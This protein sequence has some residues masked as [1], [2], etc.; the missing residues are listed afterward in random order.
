MRNVLSRV[1]L[2]R[3]IQI[4]LVL[5]A[6]AGIA[7][8]AW[9]RLRHSQDLSALTYRQLESRAA[10]GSRDPEV[11]RE[12]A[13]RCINVRQPREA[14]RWLQLVRAY[15]PYNPET[16]NLE[17]MAWAN[18]GDTER[19]K[20]AFREAIQ[21]DPEAEEP[22][23]N[24]GRMALAQGA[25]WLATTEFEAAKK[26]APKDPE[27]HYLLGLALKQRGYAVSAK[28]AIRKAL[29]LDPTH[30]DAHSALGQVFTD[31][32]QPVEG[33]AELQRAIDLGDD[34]PRT[35]AYLGLAFAI[36]PAQP[37]DPD[38]A[39]Q[40][41]RH[42]EGVGERSPQLYYGLALAYQA[43]GDYRMAETAYKQGLELTPGSEGMLYGL[44]RVYTLTG[45]RKLG[46]Q[47]LKQYTQVLE[48]RQLRE[49]LKAR[50]DTQPDRWQLR[51]AYADLLMKQGQFDEATGEYVKVLEER[52]DLPNV[53]RK[54]ARASELAGRPDAAAEADRRAGTLAGKQPREK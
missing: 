46:Q 1:V 38:T 37:T 19:A 20:K 3:R 30:S 34:T 54:L 2:R 5:V 17:G 4:L 15:D 6:C 43:K 14:L 24:L 52:P 42:A 53:Y 45:R 18:L 41:L 21:L 35:R 27:P 49:S 8:T 39:I 28:T 29:E 31:Y 44:A 48:A 23:I 12:L 36:H 22:H 10:G 26:L 9:W 51:V 25:L 16:P 40:H 7:G 33:R 32:G 47:M 11:Y 13:Y 50:A